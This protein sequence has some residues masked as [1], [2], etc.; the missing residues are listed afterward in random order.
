MTNGE[1]ILQY[2]LLKTILIKA[3]NKN[4]KIYISLV[5]DTNVK[6]YFEDIC[7]HRSFSMK[8]SSMYNIQ[9]LTIKKMNMKE[10]RW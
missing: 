10:T 7:I 5:I 6:T 9:S 4:K 2:K 3:K 1:T 8:F